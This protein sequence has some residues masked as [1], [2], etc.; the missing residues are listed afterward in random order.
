[1]KL[2]ACFIQKEWW[3]SPSIL[4]KLI[5]KLKLSYIIVQAATNFFMVG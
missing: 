3:D 4:T 1:M 2:N 5:S